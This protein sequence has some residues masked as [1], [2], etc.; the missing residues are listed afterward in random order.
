MAYFTKHLAFTPGI[1]QWLH[2]DSPLPKGLRDLS[3]DRRA[4]LDTNGDTWIAVDGDGLYT[5][6]RRVV[7]RMTTVH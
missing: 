1:S 7:D 3:G 4:L 5:K 2:K 6:Y